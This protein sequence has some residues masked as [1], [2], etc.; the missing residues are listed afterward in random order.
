MRK[1]LRLA[2]QP[3]YDSSTKEIVYAEVLV[4]L[5]DG[6]EGAYNILN[7]VKNNHKTMKFDL[8][9]LNEV[10]NYIDKYINIKFPIAVNICRE[11]LEIKNLALFINYE[12]ERRNINKDNIVIEILED[13][14]FNNENVLENIRVFN[15]NSIK[16]AL[17]DFGILNSN[18]N[19]LKLFDFDYIKIDKSFLNNIDNKKDKN[20]LSIF[21]YIQDILNI[22]CIVEGVETKE[23]LDI[24]TE[25]GLNT[26]QGYYYS[27][28]LSIR[29]FNPYDL[30]IRDFN[31]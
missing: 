25:I 30:S 28:P 26:I 31:D 23:Q 24:V 1:D 6:I 13:T 17:D 29:S 15:K 14:D 27:E 19:I 3:V 4:R 11:T 12:I 9:I 5:Y 22:K 21:K 2:I 18:L 20:I 10:L 8:D 16:I 7:S